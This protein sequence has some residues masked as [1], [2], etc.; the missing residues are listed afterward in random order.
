MRL[1]KLLLLSL[2]AGLLSTSSLFADDEVTIKGNK[3][4]YGSVKSE[5]GL[6]VTLDGKK[7]T[8]AAGDIVDIR[9]ERKSGDPSRELY[10]EARVKEAALE[11][12][13]NVRIALLE[14]VDKY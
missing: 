6:G 7:E 9:Y 10:Y 13:K 11:K 5:N 3:K 2:V 8:I 4:I 1:M 12:A 14:A